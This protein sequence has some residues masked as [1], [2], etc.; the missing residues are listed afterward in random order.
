MNLHS[1]LI[2]LI[3]HCPMVRVRFVSA[4]TRQSEKTRQKGHNHI[5][6]CHV[7]AALSQ[8]LLEIRRAKFDSHH[9]EHVKESPQQNTHDKK[10]CVIIQRMHNRNVPCDFGCSKIL[11]SRVE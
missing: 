3:C 8:N 4:L 1:I 6:A 9:S 11:T 10:R 5:E 2:I 7:T